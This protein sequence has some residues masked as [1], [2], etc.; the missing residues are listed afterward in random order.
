MK[1]AMILCDESALLD[2]WIKENACKIIDS[3]IE[4]LID[5]L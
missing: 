3:D 1:L 5:R 4:P 2:G